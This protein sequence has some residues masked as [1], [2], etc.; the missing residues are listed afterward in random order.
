MQN[1][2]KNNS[3]SPVSLAAV[4]VLLLLVVVLC[5]SQTR[6]WGFAVTPQP[7]SGVF[8]S[9]TPSSIGENYDGWHYDASDSLLAAIS[10]AR[11]NAGLVQDVATRANAWGNRGGLTSGARAGTLKH[12]YAD[13]LLNRYQ[14]RFGDRGLSTEVPYLNGVAG[15]RGAGSIR[16]DVVEGPLNNPAAIFDYK[17]GTARFPQSRID[18]I[19]R[20][21]Q[22][23]DDVP[24]SGVRPQ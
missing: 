8:E 12:S 22:F 5:L 2:A 14:R 6:V 23:G 7:A 10:G 17:F 1:A 13:G 18:Q 16:L 9:V 4:R 24:I 15:Q 19:R 21:G 11:T 20:V 3:F